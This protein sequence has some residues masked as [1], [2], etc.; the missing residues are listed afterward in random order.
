MGFLSRRM[1]LQ[2]GGSVAESRADLSHFNQTVLSAQR[3]K[4]TPLYAVG[5]CTA[6]ELS[7]CVYACSGG[8]KEAAGYS[9]HAQV[10]SL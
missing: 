5:F 9:P 4:W 1:W 2:W 8:L 6:A 7:D 10:Y 3:G